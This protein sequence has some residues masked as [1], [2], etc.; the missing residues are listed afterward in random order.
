MPFAEVGNI[1]QVT[2]KGTYN[3]QRILLVH[4]YRVA[5]V[6]ALVTDEQAA[7]V[8][9]NGVRDGAGG[10]DLIE[11][12]YLACLPAEY[13]LESIRAQQI[14]PNRFVYHEQ[15]RN[16]PGTHAEVG[17]TGNLAGVI[18]LRTE[19]AGRDQVSNRHIGPIPSTGTVQVLGELT[20]AYKTLLS[21]LAT[22]LL[23]SWSFI[24][25]DITFNPVIYHKSD[26]V[27]PLFDKLTTA[28]IGDTVRTMRR[29]TVRLGE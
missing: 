25:P 20:G 26:A 18:T 13:E 2:F 7:T 10:G 24:T 3:A 19:R 15:L 1:Y 29:R 12:K 28:I 22:A 8:I 5:A 6:D 21:T 11:T 27:P 4:T 9:I 23:Q 14:A 16:T 17:E